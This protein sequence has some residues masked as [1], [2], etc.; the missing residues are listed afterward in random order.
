MPKITIYYPEEQRQIRTGV[1][2]TW[3]HKAAWAIKVHGGLIYYLKTGAPCDVEEEYILEDGIE[4]STK[5]EIT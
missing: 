1:P 2:F 4:Y 3:G 5:L